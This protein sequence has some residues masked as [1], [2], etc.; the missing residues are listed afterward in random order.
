MLLDVIKEITVIMGHYDVEIFLIFFI[1]DVGAKNLH[2]EVTTEHID[3]LNFPILVLAV[4]KDSFNGNNF[5][6]LSQSAFEDLSKSALTD[7]PDYVN[8]V[9]EE[10]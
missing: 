8:F 9:H 4:L 7:E 10:P 6:C 1:S 3:H 2:D 5:S